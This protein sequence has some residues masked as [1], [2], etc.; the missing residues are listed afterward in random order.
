MRPHP[1]E[2]KGAADR[3]DLRLEWK[4]GPRPDNRPRRSPQSVDRQ[5][6]SPTETFSVRGT[7]TMFP[8][9]LKTGVVP[10]FEASPL[11]PDGYR[12]EAGS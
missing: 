2:L 4:D 3:R 5:N 12:I 6:F 1:I 8:S 10:A 7:P 11:G 9:L